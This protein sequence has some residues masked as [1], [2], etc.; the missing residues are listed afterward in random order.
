MKNK[1]ADK[2]KKINSNTLAW[3]WRYTRPFLLRI[4]VLVGID[5]VGAL[6]GVYAVMASKN[7]IDAATAQSA[8]KT[9]A[10]VLPYILQYVG[11]IIINMIMGPITSVYSTSLLEKFSISIR[12]D[13]F[14]KIL[15]SKWIK[16]TG[17]HSGD[18][19][20]RMTSD[21]NNVANG[22]VGIIPSI[23]TL[24][25]QFVASFIALISFDKSLAF[26][27]LILAPFTIIVS[28][29][30]GGK[31]KALHLKLQESESAFRSFIQEAISN[32]LI[33]KSYQTEQ[34]HYDKLISLHNQRMYWVFKRN[35]LSIL[36][37]AMLS[38]GYWIGYMA[39]FTRGIVGLINNTITYGMMTAF[40]QLIQRVQSPIIGMASTVP[41]IVSI[42]GSA[43]RLIEIENLQ[44]EFSE[45]KNFKDTRD[46]SVKAED[47]RI[48]FEFEDVSYS[49]ILDLDKPVD[50]SKQIGDIH[51]L[52]DVNMSINP[53]EIVTVV[54]YS[55]VGKTTLLRL[56]M[57]M[58]DPTSGKIIF[59][60]ENGAQYP[61]TV[62]SRDYISYVPQGNML[63]SGTILA[64]LRFGNETATEEDIQF[65][66]KNAC[67]DDFIKTLPDGLET[68][69]GERG[70]GL[71]E[72]QAQRVAIARALLRKTAILILDEATSALD[73]DTEIKLLENIKNLPNKPTCVIITHK[74][75]ALSVSHRVFK[76]D[77]GAM[78]EITDRSNETEVS[79]DTG[80]GESKKARKAKKQKT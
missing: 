44:K 50:P 11:L 63:F 13:V 14:K 60:E 9:F 4:S 66:I 20:A 57:I 30:L 52:K 77:A 47:R 39:A 67:I 29:V 78:R 18:L 80:D 54:G 10:S 38:I 72:G 49:Y 69:I 62:D 73:H 2:L 59:K 34:A 15:E 35:R 32:I 8:T 16:I 42:F 68:P 36:S 79:L 17:Y 24:S 75:Y 45:G 12:Q 61:A 6:L 51:V 70:V 31:L 76:L 33:V 1:Y 46:E 19:V 5:S 58:V 43:E 7:L 41:K 55:G 28:R 3:V 37:G 27:A 65:A 26:F 56:L 40:L 25:V 21:V 64:N 74:D 48:G 22:I 23:I 71:S 53:G